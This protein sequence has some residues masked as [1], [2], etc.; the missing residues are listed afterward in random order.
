MYIAGNTDPCSPKKFYPVKEMSNELVCVFV[1]LI[2]LHA[3]R[4]RGTLLSS[5]A[6]QNVP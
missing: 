5:L 6:Y 1:A 4:I 3:K 2:M